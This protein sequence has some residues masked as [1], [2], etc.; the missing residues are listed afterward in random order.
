MAR[1]NPE[2]SKAGVSTT[3][4][5]I[6]KIH[7]AIRQL[8]NGG[9][10]EALL[11]YED[12]AQHSVT[13]PALDFELGNLCLEL[14]NSA[15]A[16]AHFQAAVEF[17]AENPNVLSLLG[18][19]LLRAGRSDDA[20]EVFGRAMAINSELPV[21]L[22]G[23][24]NIYL[25]RA[26][27]LQA[28]T[29]L[30]KAQQ[31]KPSEAGIRV[32]LATTLA[33]L[34]EH[35]AALKH[36]EKGLKLD[37]ADPNAHYAYASI[38]SQMGRVDEAVVALQKTIRQ[39]KNFG[40]AYDLLARMKK[41]SASDQPFINQAE[42]VLQQGLPAQG[43]VC[44]H[45]A[46][47]KIYDDCRDWNKAFEHFSQAN[48]LKKKDYDIKRDWKLFKQVKKLFDAP[49]LRKYQQMSHSSSLP[50]FI[51]GMPRSGTTL[52]ERMIAGN[53]SAA[54]AGELPEIPRI[55]RVLMPTDD[56][57]RFGATARANLTAGNITRY[58]E[59]YLAVLRQ[60]GP[61]A[62]RIVDKLPGNYFY[63]GLISILFPNATIIHAIRHPLDVCLSCYFQN[64]TNV[65]WADEFRVIVQ[66]FSL[67]RAVMDY[68]KTVLPE[69][70]IIDVHYEQLIGEP[71]IY[72]KYLLEG[73]GLEWDSDSLDF[74]KKEKVVNTASLW[75]V[76]Q[77]I[78]NSSKMRW[79]N[80]APHIGELADGL[81]D[82]LQD[83]RQDLSENGIEIGRKSAAVWLNRIFN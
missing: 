32:N 17:D 21:V 44:L 83:D 34:N 71:E 73:C 40:G 33:R 77:P 29:F 10:V 39:H 67:Y 16:V 81:S 43:R 80:Y 11:I 62:D 55:S 14:G 3:G 8:R 49:A 42:K 56:L 78:Y 18:V 38:L 6:S 69:G 26:D 58:A 4:K 2:S 1:P 30:E 57:R 23:M 75:Q 63:L 35:D 70:R 25:D 61:D 19:A 9:R 74:Y 5:Q 64:F 59:E 41:F 47:G 36:A 51:V 28:K 15:D 27:Y 31:L 68:W 82:Y 45:F 76:R 53:R 52:M 48:L 7:S 72:G 66:I 24:G 12:V 65:G 22:H 20:L 79:R 46:L 50:V 37:S 13:N 60:S 54:G